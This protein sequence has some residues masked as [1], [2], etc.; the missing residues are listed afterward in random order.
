MS[1]GQNYLLLAKDIAKVCGPYRQGF[2][3]PKCT[4]YYFCLPLIVISLPVN[5]K[6]SNNHK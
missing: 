4:P 2:E 1:G 6:R 3:H 5:V